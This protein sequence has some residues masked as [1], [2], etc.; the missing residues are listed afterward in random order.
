MMKATGITTNRPFS[1]P[2]VWPSIR[3]QWPRREPGKNAQDKAEESFA[4]RKK[5]A[6]ADSVR[7]AAHVEYFR[8]GLHR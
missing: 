8:S 7:D 5:M 3:L 1:W 2:F 4:L 6:H